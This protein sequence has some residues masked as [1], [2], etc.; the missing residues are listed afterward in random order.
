MRL[1]DIY[2][3][4]KADHLPRDLIGATILRIGA[5]PREW[6]IEGGGLVIEY[7]P[8]GRSEAHMVV[9]CSTE[10]GMWIDAARSH[11]EASA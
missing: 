6:D 1:P 10:L 7:R 11:S 4:E 3:P 8:H 5:A 9:M 2:H